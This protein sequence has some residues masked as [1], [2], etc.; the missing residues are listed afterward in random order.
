MAYAL[1]YFLILLII[2]IDFFFNIILKWRLIKLFLYNDRTINTIVFIFTG[3]NVIVDET[4]ASIWQACKN[5]IEC[6][7]WLE[8]PKSASLGSNLTVSIWKSI[9]LSLP[10]T[11]Y[12]NIVLIEQLRG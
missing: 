7:L 10:D 8:Y 4:A 12:H 1:K 11:A 2:L 3:I 5:L 6:A 9:R